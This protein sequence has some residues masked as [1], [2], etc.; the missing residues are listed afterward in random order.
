MAIADLPVRR[1]AA[2]DRRQLDS[3][4]K[5]HCDPAIAVTF[6]ISLQ[7]LSRFGEGGSAASSER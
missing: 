5:L 4:A 1:A 6:R 2:R 7:V 3:A